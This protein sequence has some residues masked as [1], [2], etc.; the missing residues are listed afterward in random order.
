[1]RWLIFITLALATAP[2]AGSVAVPV[3]AQ[4]AAPPPARTPTAA[5]YAMRQAIVDR[6]KA[7]AT[8]R[9]F[10]TLGAMETALRTTRARTLSGRWQLSFFYR[11]LWEAFHPG[12]DQCGTQD[13][14]F[15][16]AW[17]TADPVQPAAYIG[18]AI[19]ANRQAWCVRGDG[20][21][22][23]VPLEAMARFTTLMASAR[24]ALES[25]RI[26]A[27]VDPEYHRQ[28]IGFAI[29]QDLPPDEFDRLVADAMAAGAGYEG[30]YGIAVMHYLPQWGGE[31]GD[32]DRFARLTAQR[33]MS[34]EGMGAYAR[35]MYDLEECGCL[36]RSDIDW[37]TMK[38]ALDDILAR[39]PNDLNA[40]AAA[41]MAC[42]VGQ[43][44]AAGTYFKQMLR[45]TG[46]EFTD[47]D[48][49][50]SCRMQSGRPVTSDE[51][52]ADR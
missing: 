31:R 46:P 34:T 25:H 20:P 30:I 12:D 42:F 14:G 17:A 27:S 3:A 9:D 18:A 33:T 23:Q 47:R 36:V 5:E 16:D 35:V 40:G 19:A 13:Q 7:A 21:A 24:R 8:S 4:S 48:Q 26:V 28:M 10:A 50:M 29:P 41:R 49:W 22:A 2:V 39:Y 52:A 45:D 1:M 6:A 51:I 38:Q 11:G 32:I 15:Y 43:P 44:Q 37:P